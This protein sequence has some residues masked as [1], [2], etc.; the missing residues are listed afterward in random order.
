MDYK[1]IIQLQKKYGQNSQ[2]V[3][4]SYSCETIEEF[5]NY[6]EIFLGTSK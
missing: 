1:K 2:E 6:C 4:R 5:N 3:M